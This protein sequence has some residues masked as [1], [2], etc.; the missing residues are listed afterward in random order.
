MSYFISNKSS[1][2]TFKTISQ[3]Y[4]DTSTTHCYNSIFQS[5]SILMHFVSQI[6]CAFKPAAARISVSQHASCQIVKS[7]VSGLSVDLQ[8]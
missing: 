7:D 6:F 5:S 1:I 2:L 4:F 8:N 3:F